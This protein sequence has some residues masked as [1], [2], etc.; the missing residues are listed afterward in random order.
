VPFDATVC[1]SGASLHPMKDTNAKVLRICGTQLLPI[2]FCAPFQ[3]PTCRLWSLAGKNKTTLLRGCCFGGDSL[4]LVFSAL[5]L[6]AASRLEVRIQ[7]PS[8]LA[9]AY[10]TQTKTCT[11]IHS[12]IESVCSASLQYHHNQFI[13]TTHATQESTTKYTFLYA[14]RH[15]AQSGML[16]RTHQKSQTRPGKAAVVFWDYVLC[17]E[18]RMGLIGF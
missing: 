5:A 12:P 15:S 18:P 1:I 3:R 14:K 6:M 4:T 8:R 16:W 13:H 2:L 9:I 11:F 7:T 17:N 10:H